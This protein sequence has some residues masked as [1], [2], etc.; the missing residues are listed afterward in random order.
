MSCSGHPFLYPTDE[1]TCSVLDKLAAGPHECVI[2]KK[3]SNEVVVATSL[4][5]DHDGVRARIIAK[6]TQLLQKSFHRHE[7]GSTP[8]SL[9]MGHPNEHYQASASKDARDM[10]K[11][12]EAHLFR[13]AATWEE[14]MDERTLSKR[15]QYIVH[16][17]RRRKCA[18]QRER[19]DHALRRYMIGKV[20][21]LIQ[22]RLPLDLAEDETYVEESLPVMAQCV[23]AAMYR[24]ARTRQEYADTETL[25]YRLHGMALEYHVPFYM[26]PCLEMVHG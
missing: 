19:V 25:T 13:T 14:Y 26:A 9:R 17:C 24:E 4:P 15:L 21:R 8:S 6:I 1:D 23:E 5:L 2:L 11:V 10:A 3:G 12:L 20:Q 16:H 7:D 22:L 18:W